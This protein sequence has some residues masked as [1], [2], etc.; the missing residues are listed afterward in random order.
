MSFIL[1]L[2]DQYGLVLAAAT[3]TFFLNTVHVGR[4]S[5]FRKASGIKYPNA[6]ASTEQADKD[7][8]AYLFNCAQRAHANFTENQTSFLGALLIAGVR[9]PVPAAVLGFG[10]NISRLVY[11]FGYT[12]SAGPKG[13]TAGSIGSAMCDLVLK[14]MSASVSAMFILGK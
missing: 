10:W 5:K 8:N 13:R 12:S 7:P 6:Y 9:Y 14:L 11:L 4:T 2:P 1:E 3:A